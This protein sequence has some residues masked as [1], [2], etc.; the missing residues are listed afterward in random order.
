[1]ELPSLSIR[2]ATVLELFIGRNTLATNNQLFLPSPCLDMSIQ[3]PF[4]NRW[5]NGD[6]TNSFN[7]SIKRFDTS[8]GP[9]GYWSASAVGGA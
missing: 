8:E 4:I 3:P 6:P 2:T 1:V 9:S 7:D 5:V